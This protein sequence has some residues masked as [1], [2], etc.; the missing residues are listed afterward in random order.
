MQEEAQDSIGPLSQVARHLLTLLKGLIL[1]FVLLHFVAYPPGRRV[2]PLARRL[3]AFWQALFNL[4]WEALTGVILGVFFIV[5]LL[6]VFAQQS[7]LT[8]LMAAAG[9]VAIVFIAVA[10][11]L[12]SF[13]TDI[14]DL[15]LQTDTHFYY[16]S[17]TETISDGRHYDFYRCDRPGIFCKRVEVVDSG[18]FDLDSSSDIALIADGNSVQIV[19]NGVAIYHYRIESGE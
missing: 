1:T 9:L 11:L 15:T 12:S 6:S 7:P 14:D 5:A 18:L 4:E 19:E 13:R 2:Y 17:V 3:D 16:V 10:P 8:P